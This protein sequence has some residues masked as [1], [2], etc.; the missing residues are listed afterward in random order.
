MLFRSNPTG[1]FIFFLDTHLAE[2]G[3]YAVT[4]SVNPGA[5]TGFLLADDAPL[6]PQEGGGLTFFTPPGIALHNFVYLP[7]VT[8]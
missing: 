5:S 4:I 2:P 3:G 8:R 6:R 1:S 7:V